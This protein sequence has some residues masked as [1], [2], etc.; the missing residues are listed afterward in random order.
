[1]TMGEV[2]GDKTVLI[3]EDESIVALDL[4]QRL[5]SLGY[6]VVAIAS[7]GEEA[8]EQAA[9]NQ[10]DLVLMDI[11]LKGE[12]DGV[13]A[14]QVIRA[15]QGLPVIFLTA[16]ADAETLDRAKHT[17]PY[18]YLIKPFEDKDLRTTV[19]IALYRHWAEVAERDQ[20]AF[21]AAMNDTVATLTSTLDIDEVLKRILDNVQQVVPHDE[22]NIT[23]IEGEA[24][25][26]VRNLGESGQQSPVV[27]VDYTPQLNDRFGLAEMLRSGQGIVIADVQADTRWVKTPQT[28]WVRS[29]VAAPIRLEGEVIGFINLHSAQPGFFNALHAERLQAFANQAGIAIKNA[30]LYQELAGH[31]AELEV[32]NRELDA[33]SH[34]VAHDLRNPIGVILG[35]I[36][37][38]KDYDNVP[39]EIIVHHEEIEISAERA[40]QIVK[41]LWLLAEVRTAEEVLTDVDIHPL[42]EAAI[43][44]FQRQ[45]KEQEI[46]IIVQDDMPLASGYGPWLEEVFV[47]LIGNS[48]KYIGKDNPDPRIQIRGFR[49]EGE[50]RGEVRYE[51]QDNG[52]GISKEHHATLFDMFTRYHREVANGLGLGLSIV[53]RIVTKLGGRVGIESAPGE[54]S[55]FWFVLPPAT[56]D[57]P[58][59]GEQ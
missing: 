54:G 20:R 16:Y 8:I 2:V 4:K 9:N 13:E 51:V 32:R 34:A 30:Q 23:F 33:F 25:R 44:H 18:G 3:V 10:P 31:A 48:V 36:D 57:P 1:M 19:E 14:A 5:Q 41:G 15:R 50:V 7:S 38:L 11:K 35:H 12:L 55:T 52:I 27:D 17:R 22:A 29:Y 59:P 53:N 40:L 46:E 45:I 28:E 24:A 21:A 6:K 58:V 47:N 39:E 37:M 42:V 49:Q 43:G 56:G 26:V